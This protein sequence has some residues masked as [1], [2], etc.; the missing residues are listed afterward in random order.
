MIFFSVIEF[1]IGQRERSFETLA[2]FDK[3]SLAVHNW[4]SLSY[5]RGVI[6]FTSRSW[7]V[8]LVPERVVVVCV[9]E[10]RTLCDIFRELD[11]RGGE[12]ILGNWTGGCE[13]IR[14][15]KGDAENVG[16]RSGQLRN[17][18][19]CYA[20]YYKNKLLLEFFIIWSLIN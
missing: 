15:R 9:G 14:R 20:E 11:R 4:T 17:S 18:V 13:E 1:G 16:E 10:I 12:L 8:E 6:R 2:I 5:Y 7:S 3:L 19:R